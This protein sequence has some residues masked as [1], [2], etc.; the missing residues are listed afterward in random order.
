MV[1]NVQENNQCIE[2]NTKSDEIK[3]ETSPTIDQCIHNCSFNWKKHNL[4]KEEIKQYI[5]DSNK[6]EQIMHVIRT[7]TKLDKYVLK[8]KPYNERKLAYVQKYRQKMKLAK[9]QEM[10][11]M[12]AH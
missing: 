2:N 1:D 7:I 4:I 5:D 10:Q 6:L 11:E 12:Q 8:H 9:Q 3:S